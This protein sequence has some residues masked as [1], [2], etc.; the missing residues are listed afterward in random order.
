[1]FMNVLLPEPDGAH[2]RDELPGRD[3][4]R[5]AV[6]GPN[7]DLAHLVHADEVL[8]ADDVGSRQPQNLRP[9]TGL[10]AAVASTFAVAS[11]TTTVS[12]SL[13]SPERTCV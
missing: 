2:D 7:L 4:E 11:P 13:S 5:H 6:E 8:D 1:M 10:R 3:R 9:P 12:P